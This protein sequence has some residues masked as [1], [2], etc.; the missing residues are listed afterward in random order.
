MRTLF[1]SLKIGLVALFLATPAPSQDKEWTDLFANNLRDWTRTGTGATPWRLT[2]S[3]SLVCE[4]GSEMYIPEREF[5]DGTLKFEYRF[6]KTSEKTGYK[7]SV[8]TRRTL[9]DTGCKVAL[10]DDCG[11]MTG[12]FQAASDRVKTVEEKA[13]EDAAKPIGEWNQVR[14]VLEKRS[15]VV[16]INDKQV[17]AFNKSNTTKGMIALEGEGSTVEF[18][19]VMWKDAK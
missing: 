7:A 14:I 11:Y 16:F 6:H 9:Y 12:Y 15:V 3:N 1:C 19:N 5:Y 18:R 8:W 10:G 2:A 17:A 4:R 13:P